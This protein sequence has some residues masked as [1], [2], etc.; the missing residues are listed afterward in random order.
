M[1]RVERS[2]V[3]RTW[4]RALSLTQKRTD[5]WAVALARV[6]TA[7]VVPT[8]KSVGGAFGVGRRGSDDPMGV[9][10]CEGSWTATKARDAG[11]PRFLTLTRYVTVAPTVGTVGVTLAWVR[12]SGPE[13]PEEGGGGAGGEADSIVTVWVAA[14][15]PA[16][17][18]TI[19]A[20]PLWAS[21]K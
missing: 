11:A 14:L 5:T 9:T 12:R 19:V 20:E 10:T 3:T 8:T 16:A 7:G 2:G 4:S 1:A 6:T 17:A 21:R 15:L 13:S 18:A